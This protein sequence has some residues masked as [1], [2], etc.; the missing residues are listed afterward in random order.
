MNDKKKRGPKPFSR[1]DTPELHG[2]FLVEFRQGGRWVAPK[3]DAIQPDFG[4]AKHV[5]DR[6]RAELGLCARVRPLVPSAVSYRTKGEQ[7][8]TAND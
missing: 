1:E 4:Q 3:L 2:P 6:I 7:G 5:A 8:S